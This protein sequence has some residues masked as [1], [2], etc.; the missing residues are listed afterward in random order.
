MLPGEPEAATRAQRTAAGVPL[1]ARTV[2]QVNEA[3]ALVGLEP[4]L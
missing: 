4:P 2:A 3:A 1:D